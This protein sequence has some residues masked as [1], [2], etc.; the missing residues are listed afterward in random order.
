MEAAAVN[1]RG[2]MIFYLFELHS[3]VGCITA[4]IWKYHSAENVSGWKCPMADNF[5]EKFAE[6]KIAYKIVWRKNWHE[7]WPRKKIGQNIG[8]HLLCFKNPFGQKRNSKNKIGPKKIGPKKNWPGK[9]WPEK[10]GQNIGLPHLPRCAILKNKYLKKN[11]FLVLYLKFRA[12]SS[13]IP[14]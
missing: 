8:R 4:S 10:N 12:L 9:N 11:I 2:S 6:K 5:Q 14:Q 1:N 3:L 13:T 7:N